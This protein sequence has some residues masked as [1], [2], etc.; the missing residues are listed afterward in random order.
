MSDLRRLDAA[1]LATLFGGSE[2]EVRRWCAP[3]LAAFDFGYRVVDGAARDA[4]LLEAIR[5]LDPYKVSVA[6]CGRKPEWEAGWSENLADFLASDGDLD[7]LVPKYIRPGE[8]IRLN[9]AYVQPVDPHFVKNY[10][11]TF[12]AWLMGR[13]LGGFPALYEFGCGSCSH[14]AAFAAGLPGCRVHG[15]DWATASARIIDALAHRFGWPVQGGQFDFFNP[16]QALRLD[17]EAVVLTFGALEQVGE[18]VAPFMDYLLANAP[19]RCVHVEGLEELYDE[20]DLLDAVAAR[21]HRKRNYLS[22]L[23]THLRRLEGQGLVE[24]EALHRHRFGT[25]FDDTF[26]YVVWRPIVPPGHRP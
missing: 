2:S 1:A 26:S 8:W 10:T 13:F 15:L 21:Y 5:R 24:I 17:G 7:T 6:G 16:D 14:V 18:R 9:G 25:R 22:G 11:K 12:R 3:Q 23:V 20:D 4:C 19:A